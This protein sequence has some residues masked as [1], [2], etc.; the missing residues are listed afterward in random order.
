MS[1]FK[2]AQRDYLPAP[3]LGSTQLVLNFENPLPETITL[4]VYGIVSDAMTIDLSRRIT[5]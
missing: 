5:V 2:N 4:I 1:G 3:R